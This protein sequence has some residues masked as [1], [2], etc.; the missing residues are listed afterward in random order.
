MDEFQA[1]P[2]DEI[3][4]LRQ[5]SAVSFGDS[6]L[7][8]AVRLLHELGGDEALEDLRRRTLRLVHE[9]PD[10]EPEDDRAARLAIEQLERSFQIATSGASNLRGWTDEAPPTI[11]EQRK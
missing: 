1:T 11:E 5:K 6:F 2:S 7:N 8:E 4:K 9:V 10:H 3:M